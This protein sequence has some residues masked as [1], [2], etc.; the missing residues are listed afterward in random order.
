MMTTIYL[1]RHGQDEDNLKGVLN[2]HR[3]KPLTELGKQQAFTTAT[4]IKEQGLLI[5]FVYSSPL[6]RAYTTAKIIAKTNKLSLPQKVD[7]LIERDFGVM[8]GKLV[9]DIVKLC[10]PNIL[11]TDTITYFL[12]PNNAETFPEL[13]ERSS[14]IIKYVE[15]NHKNQS[16]L[17]VTHGDIGKMIYAAFYNLPWQDVLK[18]FHFG[19]C[20]LLMLSREIKSENAHVFTQDQHNH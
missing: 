10:S 13:L 4:H 12:Q 6:E 11:I 16:V 9:S 18:S 2:G 17:L 14:K 8:E 19:N 3:N 5:D 20:E 15:K 7:L 1:A